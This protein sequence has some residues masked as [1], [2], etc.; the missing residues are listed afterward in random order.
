MLA[1][2]AVRTDHQGRGV[3]QALIRHGLQEMGKRG[4]RVA[5]TYG[6]PSFYARLGFQPLS[7]KVIRA[8]RKLSMPEGWLGQS[9]TG[10]PI[11]VIKERPACVPEFDDPVYW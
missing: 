9:L 2:V 4:V 10:E 1:P 6:D 7:E 5:V 8:P 11:P 3:G